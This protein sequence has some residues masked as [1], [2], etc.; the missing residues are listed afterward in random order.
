YVITASFAEPSLSKKASTALHEVHSLLNLINSDH[1]IHE[2]L[3]STEHPKN[4]SNLERSILKSIVKTMHSSNVSKEN[5]LKISQLSADLRNLETQYNINLLSNNSGNAH[6]VS[7][8]LEQ[9]LATETDETFREHIFKKLYSTR[10]KP[11]KLVLRILNNRQK[12]ARL[13]G[14]DNF[15][16]MIIVQ[17]SIFNSVESAKRFLIGQL[18]N[19]TEEVKNI[20]NELKFLKSKHSV[21]SIS[22]NVHDYDL[23]FL[24]RILENDLPH[25][26]NLDMES[27]FCCIK[28]LIFELFGLEIEQCNKTISSFGKKIYKHNVYRNSVFL[29]SFFYVLSSEYSTV[30]PNCHFTIQNGIIGEDGKF[31]QH[32]LI[33]IFVPINDDKKI[34]RSEF[35]C[36][37]HETGHA[38]HN[39][40]SSQ[41][42]QHLSGIR[43]SLD[44]VEIPAEFLEE[45]P[46][47]CTH[48][49]AFDS[50]ISERKISVPGP[51]EAKVKSINYYMS[52]LKA[53][54]DL[55][56]HQDHFASTK[57]LLEVSKELSKVH[58]FIEED[59]DVSFITKSPHFIT[60]PSQYFAYP[61]ANL[62]SKDIISNF[63]SEKNNKSEMKEKLKNLFRAGTD[64]EPMLSLNNYFGFN[65]LKIKL[66]L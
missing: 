9:I 54:I 12:L 27:C 51:Q 4:F 3:C 47:H 66:F 46:N 61:V 5:F 65:Y 40:L 1:Q 58:S 21:N 34:A 56:I 19:S 22:E 38:V 30:T 10:D 55:Q 26:F 13:H 25:Q 49:S 42:F 60:Y 20:F 16:E 14:F 17:N 15:A 53:L 44:F 48:F 52:T 35:Q 62:I 50:L 63:L 8:D 18:E 31:V 32:P 64:I 39:I 33:L 2:I 11:S 59:K 37:L 28:K 41:Q 23:L 45:T 57:E 7:Q 6:F 24:T 36:L 29:G 43:N